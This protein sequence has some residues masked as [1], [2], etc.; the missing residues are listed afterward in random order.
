MEPLDLASANDHAALLRV[1]TGHERLLRAEMEL[2]LRAEVER[3][4]LRRVL[5]A[6][7]GRAQPDGQCV[8]MQCRL[9][10]QTFSARR[11]NARFC[12]ACKSVR[13][14]TNHAAW[15]QAKRTEMGAT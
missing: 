4:V 7:A 2:R 9:C 15:R 14:T 5:D 8:E 13:A 1:L 6:L 11:R 3:D 10:G 12:A